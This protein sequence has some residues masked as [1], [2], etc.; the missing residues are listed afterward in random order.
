MPGGD[1]IVQGNWHVDPTLTLPVLGGSSIL[2]ET[3]ARAEASDTLG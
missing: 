1:D 2:W 3:F